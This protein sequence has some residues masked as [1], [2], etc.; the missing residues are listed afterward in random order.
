MRHEEVGCWGKVVGHFFAVWH[1][2]HSFIS[3]PLPALSLM[4]MNIL[5]L[6]G[7]DSVFFTDELEGPPPGGIKA[8]IIVVFIHSPWHITIVSCSCCLLDQE[9]RFLHPPF[10]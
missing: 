7:G 1:T 4:T 8:V 10:V 5:T 6:H 9:D 2:V 3:S